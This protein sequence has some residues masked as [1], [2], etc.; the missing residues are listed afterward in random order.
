[1]LHFSFVK[2][3]RSVETATEI[4]QY[5]RERINLE[6]LFFVLSP[7]EFERFL[8]NVF[9]VC[10]AVLPWMAREPS[11]EVGFVNI[12]DRMPCLFSLFGVTPKQRQAKQFSSV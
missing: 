4:G 9:P 10:D 12:D 3:D 2:H 1:M 7:E 11:V 6:R 8:N 5:L